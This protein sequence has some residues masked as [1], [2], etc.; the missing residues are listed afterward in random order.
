MIY[1]VSVF[2]LTAFVQS[3]SIGATLN[4]SNVSSP[5]SGHSSPSCAISFPNSLFLPVL[6]VLKLLQPSP[7]GQNFQVLKKHCRRGEKDGLTPRQAGWTPI[8]L[9]WLAAVKIPL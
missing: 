4:F 3:C 7:E 8:I 2:A 9:S 5:S 6:H 1:V